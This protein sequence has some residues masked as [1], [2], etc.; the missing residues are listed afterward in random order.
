MR[1]ATQPIEEVQMKYFLSGVLVTAFVAGFGIFLYLKMGYLNMRCDMA[2]SSIE[3]RWAMHFLDASVDRRAP[4]EK[5][6][7]E[8]SEANL[9]AGMKLYKTHCAMCHGAPDHPE[10]AF[11]HPFY[12]PAPQFMEDAPDMS[13]NQNYYIIKHGVRWTGMPAW[14]S[15][16][17]DQQVWTLTTFLSHMEKLPPSVQQ[18]WQKPPA[19]GPAEERSP[20]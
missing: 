1:S 19:G 15:V 14:G 6:P 17:S 9:A 12:P 10:K 20:K 16:L 2:P 18:E 11:G 5:N 7:V 3:S 13:E 4:E 8:A